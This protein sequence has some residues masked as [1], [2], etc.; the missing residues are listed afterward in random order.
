[1]VAKKPGKRAGQSVKI[2]RG[3]VPAFVTR[4]RYITGEIFPVLVA[5]AGTAFGYRAT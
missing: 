2:G 4:S 5:T 3:I 1:V